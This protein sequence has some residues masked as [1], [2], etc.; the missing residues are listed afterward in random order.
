MLLVVLYHF[1]RIVG[2]P[3]PSITTDTVAAT[4]AASAWRAWPSSGIDAKHN[5]KANGGS[6]LVDS[7]PHCC[8]QRPLVLLVWRRSWWL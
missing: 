8:V 3:W 6:K 4:D 1:Q 2:C 5:L 7:I